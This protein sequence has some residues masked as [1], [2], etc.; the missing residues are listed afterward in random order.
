MKIIVLIIIALLGFTSGGWMLFDG[1]RR[2][3]VGD[4]IRINGQLG[5]WRHLFYAISVNPMARGVAAVF[6][7]YGL[8]R[9]LATIGLLAGASWGWLA[10]LVSSFMILWYLPIGTVTAILTII[11]LLLPTKQT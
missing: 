6:V 11:I 7:V 9:L 3:L 8:I 2:L 4:Y 10:M 5:P 1:G